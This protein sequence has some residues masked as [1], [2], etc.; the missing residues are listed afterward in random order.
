[1]RSRRFLKAS[2]QSRPAARILNNKHRI[3]V[4]MVLTNLENS[5]NYSNTTNPGRIV[6]KVVNSKH[7]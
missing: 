1:M 7:R 4:N 5:I 2:A 3:I 6:N